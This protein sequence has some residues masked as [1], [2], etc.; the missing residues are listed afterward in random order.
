LHEFGHLT[1]VG[2]SSRREVAR[3]VGRKFGLS[4]KQIYDLTKDQ[5]G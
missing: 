1:A 5:A 3:E 2:R 4:T